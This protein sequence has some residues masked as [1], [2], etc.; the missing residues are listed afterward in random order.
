MHIERDNRLPSVWNIV[1]KLFSGILRL[2]SGEEHEIR[3]NPQNASI[4]HHTHPAMG[5]RCRREQK[6]GKQ[7]RG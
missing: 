6:R 4:V 2:I 3:A 1:T 7:T 5:I